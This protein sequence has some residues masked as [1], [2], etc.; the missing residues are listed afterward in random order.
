M[1]PRTAARPVS[2]PVRGHA[3]ESV[4][5]PV[6]GVPVRYHSNSPEVLDVAEEAF[7]RWRGAPLAAEWI[8]VPP[9]TVRIHLRPGPELP[10][11]PANIGTRIREPGGLSLRSP[12]VRAYADI[13]RRRA[14]ARITTGMLKQRAHFRY[15]VLEALTLWIVTGLDRQPIHAAAVVRGGTALLLA[16][17][18]GV[19]KS[20]LTYAALRAGL[21]VLSEDCVFLQEAPVPRVWGLPGFVHL[22]PDAV[23]WFPE[24]QG[25]SA[26]VRNNGDLKLAVRSEGPV[27]GVARAGIC[28]LAR[29]PRPGLERLPPAEV[30]RAFVEKLEDGFDRFA[31]SI[32]PRVR[33]LAEHGGWR[34]TL[35]PSAPDAVP[36]LVRMLDALDAD[37][38][39][40]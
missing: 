30:E 3:M 10:G 32:G 25:T 6:L 12:G 8:G 35:P 37:Q 1:N 28:L 22:H 20:T 7:G 11:P 18:S 21:G 29:G 33:R 19:G 2:I 23:R 34:L 27:V 39:A 17:P 13:G 31:G 38:P 9:V 26:L 36:E 5:Y 14:G 16:G 15:A 4:T 40:V 24:L